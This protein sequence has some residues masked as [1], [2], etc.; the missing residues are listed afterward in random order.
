MGKALY[1]AYRSTSLDEIV[2]QEHITAA[3]ARAIDSGN[4]S[5]AYLFTGPRGV[6]K[7]S[8]ARILAHA[9]NGLPYAA[10][11]QHLDI[12][13]IDAAS[14]NGVEDVRDLRDKVHIAPTSSKYK[15][16]IIDEVHMLSK[17]AFNALLKTLEE[18]PEHVIF[19]LATTELQKVPETI[20][21]RTQ[22]YT[23]RPVDHAKVIAHLR[24]IATKEGLQIDD[25]ALQLI[26]DHG[27]GSF[28]DS[29]SLLDQARHAGEAVTAPAVEALLGRAPHAMVARAASLVA[30]KDI[31]GLVL[32][33][34]EL[35]ENGLAPA[36]FAAQLLQLLRNSLRDGAPLLPAAQLLSLIEGLSKVSAAADPRTSL[37][38][39]LLEQV[40]DAAAP[41]ASPAPAPPAPRPAPPKP[42]A[43]KPKPSP[44]VESPAPPEVPI[45]STVVTQAV[46]VAPS[47]DYVMTQGQWL[48]VLEKL[49][50][51]SGILHG[52]LKQAKPAFE[53][54]K[55]TLFYD[56]P[57]SVK[58]TN[59]VKNKDALLRTIGEVCGVSVAL[60]AIVGEA[61]AMNQP[62]EAAPEPVAAP[63]DTPAPEIPEAPAGIANI[64]NIFGGAEVLES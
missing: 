12:I 43:P 14:N 62:A 63:D 61:P 9:V 15:V 8:I 40:T 2:G 23:F 27:G 3:L 34:D 10:E 47:G 7:T 64:S 6:G 37:E 38:V 52:T 53:A 21:S 42:S 1:R 60:E 57:F 45:E 56:K 13:E 17:A 44:K 20:V 18:P 4:I 54:G 36:Q 28:R 32:L 11:G 22:Q 41:A 48:D 24:D 26:A 31:T 29:I 19:I 5:H 59:E 49:R 30:S 33:L 16:Y 25:E 46:M 51:G 35:R 58:T 55:V 50:G 39:R